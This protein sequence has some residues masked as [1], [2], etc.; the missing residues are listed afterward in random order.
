MNNVEQQ[1]KRRRV[2][3]DSGDETQMDDLNTDNNGIIIEL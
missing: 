1:S 2:I 3:V